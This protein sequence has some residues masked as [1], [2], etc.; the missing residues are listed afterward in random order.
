MLFAIYFRLTIDQTIHG[1][2]YSFLEAWINVEVD[3]PKQGRHLSDLVNP[4]QHTVRYFRNAFLNL[5]ERPHHQVVVPA[6]NTQLL[7]THD[8]LQLIGL[9]LKVQDS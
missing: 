2:I 1:S 5:R 7:G 9:F 4:D 8:Q 3:L 6:A